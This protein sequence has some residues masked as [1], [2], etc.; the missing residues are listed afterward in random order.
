MQEHSRAHR[1]ERAADTPVPTPRLPATPP[2]R[3][4]AAILAARSSAATACANA[5]AE[6]S[7]P[8]AKP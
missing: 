7:F 2:R 8:A 1:T 5:A 3:A 6:I 4:L